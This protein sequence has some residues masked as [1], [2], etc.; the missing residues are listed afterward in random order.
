MTVEENGNGRFREYAAANA[1]ATVLFI[2]NNLG[3]N[4]GQSQTTRHSQSFMFKLG[5]SNFI[6]FKIRYKSVK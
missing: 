2:I 3:K 6:K 1:S 4:K 5:S